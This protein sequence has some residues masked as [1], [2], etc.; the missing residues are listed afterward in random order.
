M[1]ADTERARRRPCALRCLLVALVALVVFVPLAGSGARGDSTQPPGQAG[2]MDP[3]PSGSAA[4]GPTRRNM[5]PR[6]SFTFCPKAGTAPLTVAFDASASHDIDGTVAWYEWDFGDGAGIASMTPTQTH[7][8]TSPGT[9]TA[10]LKVVDDKGAVSATYTSPTPVKVLTG[11]PGTVLKCQP[12]WWTGGGGDVP[13]AAATASPP[14]GPAPLDVTLD[15]SASN[16]PDGTITSYVWDF[17]DGSMGSGATVAHTYTTPEDHTFTARLTVTDDDGH[18]DDTTVDVDVTNT[19]PTAKLTT[20]PE[21]G[22]A[23]LTVAFDGST[24][25]DPEGDL[26]HDWDFG[27]GSPHATGPTA[28]HTYTATGSYTA[29][30]TVTDTAGATATATTTIGVGGIPALVAPGVDPTVPSNIADTTRFLYAGDHPVQTADGVTPLDPDVFEAKRIAVVRGRVTDVAGTPLAGVL[31]RVREHPEYGLTYTRADGFYDLAVNGGV[32]V[33]LN[34]EMDEGEGADGDAALLRVQRRA[35]PGWQRYVVLDDVVMIRRDAQHTD[36]TQAAPDWQTHRSTTVTDDRGSRGV[37]VLMPPDTV[38]VQTVEF[39]GAEIEVTLPADYTVRAT[40]Y[41][42]GDTG[43]A[44]MPGALPPQSAYTYA[45]ELSVDEAGEEGRV[46]FEDATGAPQNV[47]AYVDNFLG[48]PVGDG[49]GGVAA[50]PVGYYDRDDAVWKAARNGQ[51]VTILAGTDDSDGDGTAEATVDVDG[52]GA[53]TPGGDDTASLLD[54][55]FTTDELEQLH[56]LY[57]DGGNVWRVVTEHFTPYDYNWP[58]STDAQAPPGW[59]DPGDGNGPCE[60]GSIIEC[61]TQVLREIFPVTGT[62]DALAYSTDRVPGR[63]AENTLQIPLTPA[64]WGDPDDP[65]DDAVPPDSLA[66]ITV[67]VGVAGHEYSYSITDFSPDQAMTFDDWDGTDAYGQALSG[68]QTANVTLAYEYESDYTEPAM[69]AETFAENSDSGSDLLPTDTGWVWE[70]TWEAPIGHW[71]APTDDLGGWSLASH[72]TYDP[73]GG[74]LYFGDGSRTDGSTVGSE[75]TNLT[76]GSGAIAVAADGTLYVAT[77]DGIRRV[78]PDGAYT[79]LAGTEDLAVRGLALAPESSP[80]TGDLFVADETSNKILRIDPDGSIGTF[81][82]SGDFCAPAT[83]PCGDGGP[84]TAAGFAG[85][86]DLTIDPQGVVYVADLYSGRVRKIATDGD[87][88]TAAGDGEG[89]ILLDPFHADMDVQDSGFATDMHLCL[90]GAVS[91]DSD[92]RVLYV[93]DT[94]ASRVRR[95]DLSTGY[96]TTLAGSTAIM[97]HG[98]FAGDGEPAAD[99]LLNMPSA[100]AVGSDGSVYIADAANVRVRRVGP[101]GVINTYAGSG[102]FCAT[103]DACLEEGPPISVPLSLSAFGSGGLATGPDGSL[104]ISDVASGKVRRVSP[105]WPGFTGAEILIPAPDGTEL[106][107]FDADGR[108]LRTLD[109]VNGETLR[110]FRYGDDGR[111]DRILVRVHDDDPATDDATDVPTGD[112]ATD[113]VDFD[114]IT[115]LRDA[116]GT[117]TGIRG[118][119][120]QTTSLTVDPATGYLDTITNPAGETVDPSY[121]TGDLDG[122]LETLTD[123]RGET[124]AFEYGAYGRLSRDAV[125]AEDAGV[126]FKALVRTETPNGWQVAISTAGGVT[127]TYAVSVGS[128]GTYTRTSTDGTGHVTTSVE[129]PDLSVS[130]TRPDGSTVEVQRTSDPRWGV[131]VPQVTSVTETAPGAD[132]TVGTPDDITTVSRG[133]LAVELADEAD[134]LS[135]SRIETAVVIDPGPPEGGAGDP[136]DDRRWTS[137]LDLTGGDGTTAITATSPEGRVDR[138]TVDNLGRTVETSPPDIGGVDVTDT[139]TQFDTHGRTDLVTHGDRSWDYAYYPDSGP[140]AGSLASLTGP[141]GTVT[142]EAHDAALRPETLRLPDG[143]TVTLG[144]NENGQVDTVG[145][146]ST[147]THTYSY[148]HSGL[149]DGYAPPPVDGVDMPLAISHDLDG[150]PTGASHPNGDTESVV[151]EPGTDRLDTSGHNSGDGAYSDTV[152]YG[153]DPTSGQL[154]SLAGTATSL[155]L[156][157]AGLGLPVAAT[158]GGAVTG[159]VGVGYDDSLRVDSTRV[160]GDSIAYGYDDDDLLTSAGAL[161]LDRD[162]AS[163]ALTGTTLGAVTTTSTFSTYGEIDSQRAEADGTTVYSEDIGHADG[164]VDAAGR[165]TRLVETV[166]GDAVTK[167]YM[168]DAMGRLWKAT[169]TRGAATTVEVFCYDANGNRAAVYDHDAACTDPAADVVGYVDT[170][171]RLRSYGDLTLDYDER[172]QIRTRTDTHGTSDTGDDDVTTFAW[173]GAGQ[174]RAVTRPDG[175]NFTYTYDAVGNLVQRNGPD[176]QDRFLYDGGTNPVATLDA[177][178]DVVQR[179]VYATGRN[180][181]DYFESDGHT[182]RIVSDH[183]GSPRV[184]VDTATGEIAQ[185]MQH[186]VWGDVTEDTA[187]GFQP[188][189]FAGGLADSDTGL[190]RFGARWYDPAL[191][192]WISKDPVGQ[193][194]GLDVYTYA[195]N[196]P[197]NLVDPTGLAPGVRV[198][199]PE[200]GWD[201]HTHVQ[202]DRGAEYI[203]DF[204]SKTG[205]T[206][207]REGMHNG[208]PLGGTPPNS[209]LKKWKDLIPEWTSKMAT[210]ARAAGRVLGVIG[211]AT[212]VFT[213]SSDVA[214]AA[215]PCTSTREAGYSGIVETAVVGGASVLAGGALLPSLLVWGAYEVGYAVGS[216]IDPNATIGNKIMDW[217]GYQ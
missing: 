97:T 41:T 28:A 88:T 122:L 9:Y 182:Y 123:P 198:D 3:V 53:V 138:A 188:F 195:A 61:Q 183:L 126:G 167:E 181:P 113:E 20:D 52:D 4:S 86:G 82:G 157:Y 187:E 179:Y 112:P 139:V 95:L 49:A 156:A 25:T 54:L 45:V 38:A 26:T 36:M 134:P 200:H 13:E 160:N 75:I 96:M 16:D 180:T 142:V 159:T 203:L 210:K 6:A 149:N 135:A 110:A 1:Q 29:T 17:G 127:R 153:Y 77:D 105:A 35:S 194:G 163:G 2:G 174:L 172:G 24:S 185:R 211:I 116:D 18:V 124:H 22:T 140:Q 133:E 43:P 55:G 125:P 90:P 102:E 169:E 136:S 47:I 206:S 5:R 44:A 8:Y 114:T 155:T 128:D 120:G 117:P 19:A 164:D 214:Y 62:D 23:P 73:T 131:Q 107:E 193:A 162:P 108:H 103:P 72:H 132:G 204:D 7:T 60:D 71:I 141:T 191:G 158:W 151:L 59:V 37:S 147:Q 176:G 69:S 171:D 50:V 92:G 119:F 83:A 111:L 207:W 48:F 104:Y 12:P 137:V 148:S 10:T 42:V 192:R 189:G 178:D 101:D 11:P 121:Y 39:L 98:G 115:I 150:N 129:R 93:A 170:Q 208:Q 196:D 27:D 57:P 84:A 168:Y 14:T 68:T 173:D 201:A 32:D 184:V 51:V 64:D 78:D 217:L 91:L 79:I 58:L 106:Y 143:N 33:T 46:H 145:M 80:Y 74:R 152:S 56:V 89:C 216:M 70:T 99:A 144:H 31:V 100:L 87:I 94:F 76:D 30:L 40:E 85:T 190:V 65:S 177:S 213:L 197:V 81:A 175:T 215:S 205:T 154:T 63:T 34:F 118:P 109:P 186:D 66:A 161:T 202:T 199:G 166:D 146:P 130:Q 15:A 21:S 165:I 212:T 67:D 209:L